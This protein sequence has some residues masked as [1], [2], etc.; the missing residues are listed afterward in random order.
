[1]PR[2]HRRLIE[3]AELPGEGRVLEVGCGTGN[4]TLLAKR[5][6]P[7]AELVG[8]DPDPLALARA[9]R[10]AKGM[11][12]VRF[13]RGCGQRLPYPDASFD[14]V[15]SSLM[16]H[17]LDPT[18][19]H[20]TLTEAAR[21]LRPGGSLHVMD[22]DGHG[23]A[24]HAILAKTLRRSHHQHHGLGDVIP[25][26]LRDAGFGE[27]TRHGHRRTWFGGLGFYRAAV[28]TRTR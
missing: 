16:L 28:G 15:L 12:G 19:G 26:A 14:R 20:Q 22:V 21:V 2:D 18:V 13:D 6:C 1:M 11:P 24:V 27:V 4:L 9:T 25:T 17:H 10:K 8:I 3:Q 5:S 23:G 7:G